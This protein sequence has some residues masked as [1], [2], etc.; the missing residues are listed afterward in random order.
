MCL[1]TKL[2]MVFL[3]LVLIPQVI[4]FEMTY[5]SALAADRTFGQAEAASLASALLL[6]LALPGLVTDWIVG[7]QMDV[8]RQFCSRIKQGK[9]SERLV[10][11][12][13][14]RDGED[15]DPLL[16]LIR[17]MNWMARKIETREKEL[18]KAIDDLQQYRCRIDEQ[19]RFLTAA[20]A[21]LLATQ[22]RLRE[23]SAE[24][25]NAFRRMQVMALTDP[26]TA[27]ANR[28]CF[29]EALEKCL[30]STDYTCRP[31]SMLIFDI[32]QFKTINDD[33]G[34]QAGDRVLLE[35]TKIIQANIRNGDLA[36]RIGGDEYAALLPGACSSEAGRMACSIQAAVA[37]H[38]FRLAGDERVAVTASIGICTFTRLSCFDTEKLYHYADQALYHSK[39]SG[40]NC[41]AVFDPDTRSVNRIKCA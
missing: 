27:L 26:L 18:R 3:V 19:N 25:E 40:R 5:Q 31:L 12:N 13:E 37:D 33:Y 11:P 10:L 28:R 23:Q 17:D 30:A 6:V 41:V 1:V 2:R 7:R 9:Y 16:G 8:L 15:E 21:E 32:D 24:L 29:F 34:H 39:H 38:D 14:P 35:M 36:A 20:N 22:E 4:M